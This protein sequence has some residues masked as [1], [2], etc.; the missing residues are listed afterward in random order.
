[1]KNDNTFKYKPPVTTLIPSL[2]ENWLFSAGI[3]T[4]RSYSPLKYDVDDNATMLFKLFWYKNL[5]YC[6]YFA[7]TG[8]YCGVLVWL[9]LFLFLGPRGFHI[10]LV[11]SRKRKK[12]RH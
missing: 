12:M 6:D 3:M 10:F 5:V 2:D 4:N 9:F 8:R 11:P 7:I 1:M